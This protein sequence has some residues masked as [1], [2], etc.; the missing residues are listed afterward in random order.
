MRCIFMEAINGPES[1]SGSS[2]FSEDDA[3]ERSLTITSSF[4]FLI[5][6]PHLA[7][8]HRLVSPSLEFHLPLLPP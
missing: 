8:S 5:A 6:F 7:P 3:Q 4:T 2:L 1:S